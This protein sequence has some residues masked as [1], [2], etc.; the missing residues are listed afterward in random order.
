MRYNSTQDGHLLRR[1][2]MGPVASAGARNYALIVPGRGLQGIRHQSGATQTLRGFGAF[3][4]GNT[5]SAASGAIQ[6]ASVGAVAGPIGA[7]VGAVVGAVAGLFMGKSNPQIQIDKTSA[8][9]YFSQYANVAGTVS[10]RSIGVNNMD[11]V[12]RGACFEGHFPSWGNQ[13]ELPDSLMSMPGSP[14][15]NNGNCFAPLWRYART[16]A[17]SPSYPKDTGNNN[18]PV[19]DAKT[20][21]DR[22]VWPSNSKP[23]DT[24]PWATNTDSLG[25]QIIYDAADAYIATQD[26]T[27]YPLIGQS[28][29]ASAVALPASTSTASPTPSPVAAPVASGGSPTGTVITLTSGGTLSTPLGNFSY[30]PSQG[31]WLKDGGNV[32]YST[33]ISAIGWD[34]VRVIAQYSN[35]GTVSWSTA[36]GWWLPYTN[37]TTV[38]A[39]TPVSTPTASTTT[40]T[41]PASVSTTPPSVGASISSAMDS[42][43]G[44]MVGLPSGATFGGLSPAGSWLV[45]YAN[46][47][48]A[49]T[50]TVINGSLTPFTTATVAG[51]TPVTPTSTPIPLGYTLT[52][53]TVVLNGIQYPLYSDTSGNLSVWTGTTMVP[54]ENAPSAAATT[55]SVSSGGGGGFDPYYSQS[56]SPA[57][58]P[59][60]VF[61]VSSVPGSSNSM[62]FLGAAAVGLYLLM[63]S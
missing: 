48:N 20:F 60:P 19:R 41:A 52:S 32:G 8:V 25:R 50:Y 11:M 59:N 43:T 15:G 33:Q 5:T 16:G 14:Y 61:P 13:T 7:A 28:V 39:S 2:S 18:V 38:P 35:G 23:D 12:F 31:F 1:R 4:T 24:N 26:P 46:G 44:Q 22:Y 47:L 36:S 55:T 6:G 10:G 62:L 27:T 21:V 37:A 57:S 49:G 54:Y 56:Q 58:T 45:V 63:G 29:T 51:A 53:Q 40:N 34:G 30:S 3:G 42:A 9:N 17:P